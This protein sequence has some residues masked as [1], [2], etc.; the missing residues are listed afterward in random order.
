MWMMGWALA[1]CG[2]EKQAPVTAPPAPSVALLELPI[3]LRSQAARP[4]DAVQVDVTTAGLGVAGQH[5]LDLA[6]GNV[7][8]T[9]RQG[10]ELPKL[11]Q[12]LKAAPQHVHVAMVPYQTVASVI[13]SAKAAGASSI[14]FHVRSP[15]ASA[16]GYLALDDFELRAPSKNDEAVPVPGVAVRPWSDFVAQWEAVQNACRAARTGSCASKPESVADG[17]D[18]KLVLHAA[19]QGV[20]VD[21]FR[22]GPPPAVVPPPQA[23][24]DKGKGSKHAKANKKSRKKHGEPE[25]PAED[26]EPVIPAT[27]A[28]FQFRAQEA[29]TV[30]SPVSET[31]KPV[32]GSSACGVVVQA[33]KATPFLRVVSLLGAA[34]PDATPAPHVVFERP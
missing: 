19:G 24:K 11:V 26:A 16:V 9:E 2:S 12:A 22:I 18:L 20:N 13:A 25:A 10:D 7:D 1:A 8:T 28:L 14:V 34:F 31:I 15:S 32:C 33:E 30:P 21:F 23:A 17:G 3:A 27:E 29:V 5:V 4:A 6:G